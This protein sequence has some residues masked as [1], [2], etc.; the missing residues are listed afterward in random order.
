MNIDLQPDVIVGPA[1]DGDAEAHT[2][3]RNTEELE[4][5]AADR[6]RSIAMLNPQCQTP[7]ELDNA[8]T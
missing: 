3:V 4:A 2:A 8:V 5:L 1:D 6:F 7:V